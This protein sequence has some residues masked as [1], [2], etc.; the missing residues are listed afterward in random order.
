MAFVFA[1]FILSAFEVGVNFQETALLNHGA[2]WLMGFTS[3]PRLRRS[4]RTIWRTGTRPYSRRGFLA[5]RLW[6]IYPLF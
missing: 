5:I 2:E 4:T 1:R 3:A 6:T